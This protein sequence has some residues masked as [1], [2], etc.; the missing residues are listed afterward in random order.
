MECGSLFTP[1]GA[2]G[3]PLFF[4]E[5]VFSQRASLDQ[6]KTHHLESMSYELQI[7]QVFSF[8][9]YANWWG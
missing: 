7:L 2:E 8:D 4:F 3:L 6:P 9:I 1:S 5:G